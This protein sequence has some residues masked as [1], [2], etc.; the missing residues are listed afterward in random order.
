MGIIK[1][2][3][4]FIERI[5]PRSFTSF[6]ITTLVLLVI[7][8][9][10]VGKVTDMYDLSISDDDP[11][12][13]AI[14]GIK[15]RFGD[16]FERIYPDDET[17]PGSQQWQNWSPADSMWFYTITQGSN[18]MPYDFF[19]VLEQA[20]STKPFKDDEHINDYRYIPLKSTPSNPDALPLG[21]VKD[22]YKGKEYMGFTCAACHTSQINYNGVGMRIDGGP[23]M[24]DMDNF[25]VALDD[26]LTATWNDEQKRDRFVQSV[27]ARNPFSRIFSGGRNFTSADEIVAE[28]ETF[29]TRIKN[30][31]VINRSNPEYGYAR[32]DAFGRIYNR[33]LEHILNKSAVEEVIREVLGDS[34]KPAELDKILAGLDD[35]IITNDEFGHLFEKLQPLLTPRQFLKI[36]DE[37]FIKPNAP[38]SYPFLWDIAQ[39]D[40]VQWNG[41]AANAGVGPIGRNAGEVIGV[42]GTLDWEER[43]GTSLSAIIGGQIGKDSYISYRSSINVRNLKH[44]EERL[45]SLQSPQWPEAILGEID[46]DK[47]R[48]G[49]EHFEKLCSRCHAD[50]DR[51]APDRRVVAQMLD[52]RKA[53]T[54]K[55]MAVNSVNSVGRS[56]ILRNQYQDMGSGTVLIENEAPVAVL[57][58][59]ATTNVVATPDYDH[60]PIV[61]WSNWIYD[62][63]SSLFSNEIK[64]SIKRGNYQPDTTSEPFRSLL[65]YKARP[66][67]GIW[68]TAPYLH[69]GSVPTLYDLLLPKKKPGDLK[70]DGKDIA[71]RPDEFRTGSRE[72]DPK[73]V[74]FITGGYGSDDTSNPDGTR[75]LTMLT[76]DEARPGNSNAGHQ[77]GKLNYVQRYELVEYIKT[78]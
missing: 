60:G 51:A 37:I 65:A 61:R 5:R 44:I 55:A 70:P 64:S 67:N 34:L 25:L 75:F 15:D 45:T 9:L 59:A 56:G 43:P 14:T 66:L 52:I 20:E 73:N 63:A 54:D 18:V 21:F 31:T 16:R 24:S 4:A 74:G 46:R 53:G 58:T 27:L 29:K 62:L 28:L 11:T 38:V 26:A 71:Y 30:Y 48:R 7:L 77:Y 41:I 17:W 22:T 78:L 8:P 49:R 69:N 47:A 2:I 6:V 36:R 57:L 72:F 13:G 10:I 32:L 35:S 3:L 40:Y 23:A 19:M 12:R 50:I 42:F 68:A 76:G 1:R 33:V 39:H